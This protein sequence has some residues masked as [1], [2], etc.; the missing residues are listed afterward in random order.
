MKQK[1][2]LIGD[3][4]AVFCWLMIWPTAFGASP[5]LDHSEVSYYV[6]PDSR[7]APIR[8]P[9]DWEKRRAQIVAG[10]EEVMGPLPRP[11]SPVPLDVK[12]M[13][14]HQE[15]GYLRRKLAYHTDDAKQVV[16]AW[17]LLPLPLG[18]GRPAT[19]SVESG[20]GASHR[21]S[22]LCL[23]QTTPNGKDSPVGLADRP[24]LH[25]A[26]E[27]TKRGYVTLSPD[28]PSFGESKNY[29]F[30]A[31]KYISGTMKA[32][33]DNT[34]AIDLLQS[35][36]E[37][38]PDRIGVIGHSL[39]GHNAL[40]TAVFDPRIKAVVTSCGFTS[41]HK[42]KGGDLRGWTSP[43]YMPIIATK[44]HNSPDEVPFDFPEVLAAIAPRAVFIN[45]PLHD[46]NF[47]VEGVRKCVAAARPVYK[48]LGHPER[49]QVDHPACAHDF[50]DA[51]R[52]RCYS[53]LDHVFVKTSKYR[54]AGKSVAQ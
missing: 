25:Y 43:R 2:T 50:P 21:P 23:H 45:A 3:L 22:M 31:D 6:K 40:F 30:D 32:I 38:D 44:Y 13:E 15:D 52:E 49:L 14:E 28:Y 12:I 26:L 42:Y 11:A 36:P 17:L 33:Y 37:V 8:T 47:D 16:H 19:S 7:R 35:L 10:M 48:L 24:S 5:R 51:E 53:F 9:A 1:Q 54:A 20:E 18:E 34:R 46:E 39:G 27:L 41:F 4:A 29:D